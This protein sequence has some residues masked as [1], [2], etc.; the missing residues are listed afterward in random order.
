M[1]YVFGGVLITVGA[2]LIGLAYHNKVSDGFL[3]LKASN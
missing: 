1:Q 3:A 2:I